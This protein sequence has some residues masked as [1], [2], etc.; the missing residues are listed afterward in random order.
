M[1]DTM[2]IFRNFWMINIANNPHISK[3]WYV[4]RPYGETGV[5]V[6]KKNDSSLLLRIVDSDQEKNANLIAASPELLESLLEI[7]NFASLHIQND[8]NGCLIFEKARKVIER[9]TSEKEL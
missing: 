8:A 3:K 5:Y 7:M 1:S 2:G 9:A 4:E 6:A